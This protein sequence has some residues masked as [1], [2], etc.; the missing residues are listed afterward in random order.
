MGKSLLINKNDC[1]D[2][3]TILAY[4]FFLNVNF[5]PRIH[6]SHLFFLIYNSFI[7]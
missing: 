2:L 5:V 3:F 7:S 1:Y 4:H 6:E